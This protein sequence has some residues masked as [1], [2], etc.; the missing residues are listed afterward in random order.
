M[1][2]IAFSTILFVLLSAWTFKNK[3]EE[4]AIIK[5][6]L[7]Y[8]DGWTVKIGKKYDNNDFLNEINMTEQT[9]VLFGDSII[10]GIHG[11]LYFKDSLLIV[12]GLKFDYLS[13]KKDLKKT[14][15][16][17]LKNK[18][19]NENIGEGT[20]SFSYPILSLD[21][22]NA[23]VYLNSYTSPL[24]A[25]TELFILEKANGKWVVKDRILKRIS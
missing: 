4:K 10:N 8:V 9:Y 22:N 14:N 16:R 17:K 21:G 1:K 23:I 25:S 12:E 13:L 11:G 3:S 18:I 6:M 20:I 15:K 19:T 5:T 2:T 7:D 24:A